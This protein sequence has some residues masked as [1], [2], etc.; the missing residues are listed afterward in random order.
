MHI[1]NYNGSSTTLYRNV[2]KYNMRRY[3]NI[4]AD[5]WLDL[6]S[7]PRLLE[8]TTTTM[9][10]PQIV[11]YNKSLASLYSQMR[12]ALDYHCQSDYR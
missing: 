10:T 12:T 6:L 9:T 1:V 11:V 4:V 3:I 2:C 5:G 7:V 8:S